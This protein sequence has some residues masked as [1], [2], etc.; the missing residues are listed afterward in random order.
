MNAF[1]DH[2]PTTRRTTADNKQAGAKIVERGEE[3]DEERG[4]WGAW[5]GQGTE[6]AAEAQ[7]QLWP[8]GNFVKFVELPPAKQCELCVCECVCV[9]SSTPVAHM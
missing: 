1:G 4:A 8:V 9:L 5:L 3:E 7:Q 6:I 2:T